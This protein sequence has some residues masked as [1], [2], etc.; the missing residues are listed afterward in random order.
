MNTLLGQILDDSA[1]AELS[2]NKPASE[3]DSPS[4]YDLD[5]E[6]STVGGVSE[7]PFTAC[8]SVP[9]IV[10]LPFG[11]KPELFREITN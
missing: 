5:A 11:I 9:C 6:D 8:N 2:S 3:F 4:E 10:S 1:A 7:R